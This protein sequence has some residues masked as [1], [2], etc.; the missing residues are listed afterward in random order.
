MRAECRGTQD[1]RRDEGDGV[2]LEQVGGHARAV[3][4]VVAHVVGDRRRVARVVLRD[5]LLDLADQVRADVG[6]LGEDAAAD[7][8]EHREQGGPETEAFEDLRC[9]SGVDHDHDRRAEQP[10][11][12]RGHP[13][14]PTR[15]ERDPGRLLPTA[16]LTGGGR[17]PEVGP[18]GQPHPEVADGRGERGTDHEEQGPA[19]PLVRILGGEREQEEEHQS[20]EHAEC[21]EL[22][23]QVGRRPFLDGDGDLLH[24]AAALPGGE[25]LPKQEVSD[26]ESGQSDDGD[27]GDDAVITPGQL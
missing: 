13:D 14:H 24:L 10:K 23:A 27:D 11:A 4:D 9:L 2:G 12:D 20:D 19:D 22:P 16:G 25:Y 15:A 3:T 21:A 26:G 1:Q 18:G 8:H 5:V 17:D 7:P 6:R